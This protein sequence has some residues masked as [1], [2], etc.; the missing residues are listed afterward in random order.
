MKI[1]NYLMEVGFDEIE[2]DEFKKFV[3]ENCGDDDIVEFCN[4]LVLFENLG[5]DLSGYIWEK[6]NK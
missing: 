1:L 5:K 4:M 2:L 3:D 6:F